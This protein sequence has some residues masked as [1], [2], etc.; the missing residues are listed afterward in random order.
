M[1]SLGLGYLYKK[2]KIEVKRQSE[3]VQNLTKQYNQELTLTKAEFKKA[4]TEWKSKVDSLLEANKIAL[5]KV[6]QVTLIDIQ[7]KDTGS[8]K[9]VYKDISVNPDKTFTIPVLYSDKCWG[10][11]G[12]ILTLDKYSK[13]EIDIRTANNSAQLLVTRKRFLGFLWWKKETIFKAY[14]DCGEITF[15]KIDFVK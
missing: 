5:K 7:Y 13:L 2:N 1:I 11:E 15:T 4:E 9:I 10:M 3:N 6:K 8:V 14:T 12:R